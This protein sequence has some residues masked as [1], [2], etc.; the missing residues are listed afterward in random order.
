MKKRK[1]TPFFVSRRE[2]KLQQ[3]RSRTTANTL[4]NLDEL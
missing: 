4:Q 2:Q 3:Q 1:R